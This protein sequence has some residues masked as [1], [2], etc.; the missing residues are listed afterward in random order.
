[1]KSALLCLFLAGCAWS[2]KGNTRE[3]FDG[4]MRIVSW[5]DDRIYSVAFNA[6]VAQEFE[7]QVEQIA[8]DADTKTVVKNYL[9]LTEGS[10][11]RIMQGAFLLNVPKL[12]AQDSVVAGEYVYKWRIRFRPK[13]FFATGSKGG[14]VY[15]KEILSL[16]LVKK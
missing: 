12:R 6:G 15:T 7:F 16:R 2:N 11:Y 14:W 10:D 8:V 9:M 1:M 3:I 13:R 4:K 5:P